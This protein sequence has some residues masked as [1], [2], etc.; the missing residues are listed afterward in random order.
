VRFVTVS[1][2]SIP[3]GMN[4]TGV[5]IESHVALIELLNNAQNYVD[6]GVFYFSLTGGTG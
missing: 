1:A 5:D 3:L 2:Q 6:F 4:V